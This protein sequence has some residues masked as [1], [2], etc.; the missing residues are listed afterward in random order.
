MQ[1]LREQVLS[2]DCTLQITQ[3]VVSPQAGLKFKH[4]QRHISFLAGHADPTE[5]TLVQVAHTHTKLPQAAPGSTGD[6]RQPSTKVNAD[7]VTILA[8]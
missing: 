3:A 4:M 7:E 2:T 8:Q 5:V 1:N 6:H